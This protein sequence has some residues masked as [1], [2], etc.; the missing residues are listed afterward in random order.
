M[1]VPQSLSGAPD[2]C[3]G[4]SNCVSLAF[5]SS[6][7]FEES[8]ALCSV[9][10]LHLLGDGL[11]DLGVRSFSGPG[12][13]HRRPGYLRIG[14]QPSDHCRHS[15]LER[16]LQWHLLYLYRH[17]AQPRFSHARYLFC[18][19]QSYPDCGDQGWG[20]LCNLLVVLPFSQAW[21]GVGFRPGPGRRV[22]SYPCQGGGRIR[23]F[24]RNERANLSVCLYPQHDR[25]PF[26]H[27]V[28]AQVGLWHRG[29]CEGSIR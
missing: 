22:F 5:A 25:D 20:D 15:P 16:L 10:R 19:A 11:A 26:S 24:D 8:G 9:Y 23:A 14:V 7:P 17:A 27:S 1:G 6:D 2:N 28:G 12:C 13:I 3:F 18:P 21:H 29:G 4:S